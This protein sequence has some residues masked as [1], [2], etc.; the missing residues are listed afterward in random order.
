MPET[1]A[2]DWVI[3]K[4]GY[5]YRANRSGYTM[6][7]CAAGRYTEQE[8]RAE[9]RVEPHSISA[10]PLSEF[11]TMPETPALTGTV[12]DISDAELLRRAVITCRDRSRRKGEKH[13]RWTAVM[14]AFLLG[15]T[16]AHQLC[17]RFGL[18]PNEEVSR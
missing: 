13:P 12:A 1:P 6:E 7:V 10:H 8:A 14:D 11:V 17:E 3:R 5:F 9:A 16:Y 15:S 18:N 2:R 4:N